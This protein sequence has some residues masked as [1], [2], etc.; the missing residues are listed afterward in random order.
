MRYFTDGK[1]EWRGFGSIVHIRQ[2]NGSW[3]E[4]IFSSCSELLAVLDV[5]ETDENGDRLKLT[6]T[7]IDEIRGESER[8]AEVDLS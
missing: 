4:S 1:T 6:Q 7:E 8:Q 3:E 2:E 5:Y